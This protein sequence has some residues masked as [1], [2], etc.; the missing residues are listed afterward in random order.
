MAREPKPKYAIG[1]CSRCKQHT[2]FRLVDHG[3]GS[4]EFWGERGTHHDYQWESECCEAP[5][6]GEVD[7]P[8]PDYPDLWER[9]YDRRQRW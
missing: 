9:E 3:I 5:P 8:E 6:Q 4:Y 1:E 2:A 7:V